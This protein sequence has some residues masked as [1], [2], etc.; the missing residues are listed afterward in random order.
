MAANHQR[1]DGPTLARSV[2]I[3]VVLSAIWATIHSLLAS[4][5]VKQRVRER[6]GPQT[7]RWYR[8]AFVG[9]TGRT[10]WPIVLLLLLLP[11]R[12]LYAVRGPWRRL[13]HVGQSGHALLFCRDLP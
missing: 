2:L 10:L 9:F 8:V 11:N 7:D 3:L 12:L 13:M 4:Q 6:F 5:P 1:S